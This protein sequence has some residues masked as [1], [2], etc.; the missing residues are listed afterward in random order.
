MN[1]VGMIEITGVDLAHFVRAA[2]SPSRPQGLGFMHYQPGDLGDDVVKQI[3]DNGR[4]NIAV[5]MDYV[6]GRA[7]KMTVFR[8]GERL[9]I[10]NSWYDHSDGALADLLTSVGLNADLIEKA[11]SEKK[12]HDDACVDAALA[13]LRAIGGVLHVTGYVAQDEMDTKVRDGLFFA[14]CRNLAKEEYKGQGEAIWTL[15]EPQE[16]SH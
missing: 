6:N 4:G 10:N 3:L 16:N 2:Y 14:K 11:R 7:C 5:S 13:H 12:A 15:T 9:F 8:D 1:T